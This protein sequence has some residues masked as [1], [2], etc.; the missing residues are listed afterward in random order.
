[1]G[2]DTA[3]R[4]LLIARGADRLEHPGGTLLTHLERVE[5]RLAGW[6]ARDELRLAGLCHAFYGTDGFPEGLLPLDRRDVLAEAIGAEAEELVHFY[7]SC[8]RKVSYAGMA[9]EGGAFRDRFTE[10]T[11]T[12]G[13]GRRADFAELTAA[14]ELDLAVENPEFRAEWGGPLLRLFTRWRSLL[15]E[16]AF[17]DARETLTLKGE[18]REAFL[19]GLERGDVLTGVVSHIASFHVTFVELGGMEGTMNISEVAWGAYDT[20]GDVISEGQEFPFE[21][22]GVDMGR[23]KIFLSRKS[24][25]PDPLRAFARGGFGGVRTGRVTKRLPSGVFVL[26]ADGVEALVDR[27]DLD[28]RAPQPGDELTFEVTAVNVATQRVRIALRG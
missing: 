27:D 6:G 5:A 22:L 9:E 1:M 3:A 16:A 28:G 7:A 20:P 12:P 2:R 24:L 10:E 19:N 26:V 15:S 17:T 4:N 8:D 11:H 25:E 21:V 14:N 13:W 18:E 23:E